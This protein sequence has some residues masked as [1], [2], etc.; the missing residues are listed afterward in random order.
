M[1]LPLRKRC[2]C[3]K[4]FQAQPVW[5]TGVWADDRGEC[6]DGI[7]VI[8]RGRCFSFP[9]SNSSRGCGIARSW[10]EKDEQLSGKEQ[11]ELTNTSH[12]V[13]SCQ[14]S[15]EY[16]LSNHR[17]LTAQE[18]HIHNHRGVC[19]SYFFGCRPHSLHRATQG[20]AH[21]HTKPKRNFP[22]ARLRLPHTTHIR[23]LHSHQSS[24]F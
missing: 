15:S 11:A 5:Q 22:G 10:L 14:K 19:V 13:S 1:A 23:L 4:P 8:H 18:I 21:L 24:L 16:L 12:T 9:S 6:L 3:A 7:T 2:P 17:L 20:H